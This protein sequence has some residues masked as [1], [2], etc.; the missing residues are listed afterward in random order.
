MSSTALAWAWERDLLSV[1]N[2]GSYKDPASRFFHKPIFH[3]RT[4]RNAGF[5]FSERLRR[6]LRHFLYCVFQ[7]RFRNQALSSM[8]LLAD[9]QYKPFE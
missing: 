5:R 8:G 1:S 2:T 9:R 6:A 3:L 4:P 7:R